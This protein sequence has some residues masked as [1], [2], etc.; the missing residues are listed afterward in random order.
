[1]KENKKGVYTDRQYWAVWFLGAAL[2]VFLLAPWSLYDKLWVI[3]SS[4]CPQRPGH[5][6]FFGGVQMPI[7]AREG[8]IFAGFLLGVAYLV[9]TGRARASR[10]PSTKMLVILVGFIGLMGLDGLN[11]VAY[12]L[13]WPVP[14]QPNL[15]LRSGTGLLAGLAIAGIL[16]PVF[17]ETMWQQRQAVGS[18]ESWRDLLGAVVLLAIFWAVGLTG[19]GW[20]LYPVSMVAITGQVMLFLSIA[21]IIVVVALRW[22]GSFATFASLAPWLLVGLVLVTLALGTSATL[23]YTLFG[24]GPLPALR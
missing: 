9:A 20:L 14:Y 10:L 18:L 13:Y 15:Y 17:N 11:A 7:E 22:E 24:P 21:T 8:G 12:D 3:A 23:R 19:W 5:T 16:W 6:L 1:M 4:I 2:L